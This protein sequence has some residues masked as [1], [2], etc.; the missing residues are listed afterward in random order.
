AESTDNSWNLIK[1]QGVIA[2]TE[3][4]VAEGLEAAKVF[5]RAL[6]VAQQALADT[7]AKPVREFPLFLDHQHDGYGIGETAA[8]ERR[9]EVMSTACKT[10][11]E[12][13]TDVPLGEIAEELG[14][15]GKQLEGSDKEI[16]GAS[17]ALTKQPVREKVLTGGTRID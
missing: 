7:A 15:E 14:G 5:V 3:A 9:H 11:R 8:A 12:E 16:T 4:V 6:C 1:E 2:P 13:R 17:R 10:E